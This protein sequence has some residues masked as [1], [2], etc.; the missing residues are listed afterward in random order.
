[1]QSACALLIAPVP[2]T[3]IAPAFE[4]TLQTAVQPVAQQHTSLIFPTGL[5]AEDA[6]A[7]S[8]DAAVQELVSSVQKG[9]AAAEPVLK[10][11]AEELAPVAQEA[12][13]SAA[14]SFEEAKPYL[15]K[16]ATDL[17]PVAQQAGRILQEDLAPALGQGLLSAGQVAGTAAI[18][19]AKS[20][21]VVALEAA[22][23]AAA[24]AAASADKQIAPEQKATL[25]AGAGLLAKGAEESVKLAT[26]VA[27]EVGKAASPYVGQAADA[28]SQAA[29]RAARDLFRGVLSDLDS[30][31]N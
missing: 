23:E 5:L 8:R 15:Q 31:V 29:G 25:T 19:A 16:T 27:E 4:A 24:T 26:P 3:I 2:Q 6:R 13:K 9:V 12:A 30:W 20:I 22:K 18:S 28:A 17:A 21:S 7:A 11:T 14:A 10:K 1:M